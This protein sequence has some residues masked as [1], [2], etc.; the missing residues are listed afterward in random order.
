MEAAMEKEGKKE[1]A[2][3]E[4]F[5]LYDTYGFP[6]D[7]TKEILEEKGFTVDE[8]GF[9]E[10]MQEQ[11]VKA[12]LARKVTNYMG[13]DVTVYESIDPNIT[14]EFVGYDRL[15][16]G[17]RITVLTTE[18]EIVDALTDGETGTIFV[19]ETPFYATM[20]GQCADTGMIS[21]ADGEFEVIDTVKMLGGKVVYR[22]GDRRHVQDRGCRNPYGRCDKARGYVQKPQ[23]YPLAA[24]SF[25]D[26]SG[27]PCGTG[28]VLCGRGKAAF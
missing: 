21:T 27:N 16:H 22:Q 17:S 28:G 6:L 15:S 9:G 7:L 25:A 1:L 8:K 13:A 18:T 4:A 20:G 11:K 26:G 10:A 23:R 24:E 19:E 2:G 14:T 12:R 5:K 3:S